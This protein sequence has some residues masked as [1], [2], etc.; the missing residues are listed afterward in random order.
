MMDAKIEKP[1]T[2]TLSG[3]KPWKVNAACLK[4]TSSREFV[5]IRGS[6][7][8][9]ARLVYPAVKQASRSKSISS[10][11]G[12]VKLKELRNDA[13]QAHFGDKGNA[14]KLFDEPDEVVHRKKKPCTRK[15]QKEIREDPEVLMLDI[16]TKGPI[17]IRVLRPAHAED[18]LWV[19]LNS[20]TVGAVFKYV[21][22]SIDPDCEDDTGKRAYIRGR[23]DNVIRMGGGRKAMRVGNKLQYVKTAV[24]EEGAEAG[25]ACST[26]EADEAEDEETLK[27]LR[28][29]PLR[30]KPMRL[31]VGKTLK[32]LRL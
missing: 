22:D 28:L 26:T 2:I 31:E 10:C 5:R 13:Q 3:S 4:E 29:K 27:P 12:F 19:E 23:A 32:P 6:D 16:P 30:L 20:A 1:T 11:K 17:T 14:A 24:D 7:V 18:D 9:I 21:R 8:A 15:E 25:E